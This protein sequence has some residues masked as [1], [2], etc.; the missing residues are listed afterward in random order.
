M[1]NQLSIILVIFATIINSIVFGYVASNSNNNKTNAAYLIFLGFIIMYTI[2]DCII[3]QIF[4]TNDAKDFIVKIQ[5]AL[6]MPL[7][8]FFLNF[9]YKFLNKKR[10]KIYYYFMLSSTISIFGNILRKCLVWFKIII[11]I[12]CMNFCLGT[13]LCNA[14]LF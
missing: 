10:D 9:V 13:L 5:A 4:E 1:E 12:S 2:F 8:I 6:W 3:I 11:P 14:R 7:S